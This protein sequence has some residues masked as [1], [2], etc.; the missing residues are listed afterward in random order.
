[1]TQPLTIKD[2]ADAL[3]EL[4]VGFHGNPDTAVTAATD[5]SRKVT[6]GALFCA[7]RGEKL[8]GH[9]FIAQ[10][11]ERGAAGV[12]LSTVPENMPSDLPYIVV[13][14]DYRAAGIAAE[15]AAGSP[16][17]HFKVLAVTG[18]N[19]KTTIAYLLREVL[20][21]AGFETAMIG[22][23]EYDLG[24]GKKITADRTTPTPFY[25]QNLFNEVYSNN[26][27]YCVMELSSHAIAQQRLGTLQVDGAIFTNLTQDHLDYHHTLENYFQAKKLLF[28]RHL[29]TGSPAV[30]NAD[31]PYGRR[32]AYEL[33]HNLAR[34]DVI[35]FSLK[36]L[37][38]PVC[39]HVKDLK[40]SA[41]G[42]EC[43]LTFPDGDWLMTS[44]LAG[45]YNGYNLAEVAILAHA[46][47]LPYPTVRQALAT[48]LGA[49][50]RLQKVTSSN[51][52]FNVFVD[53]AHTPDALQNVISTVRAITKGR[54]IVVFGCGGDRDR[55]K[56]PIMGGVVASIADMAIVTSDNPRTEAP[57]DI[58]KDILRGIPAGS[59]FAVEEDRRLAIR[60]ALS[61]A[62]AGD[63]VI[64]AGKGHEDYQEINGVKHHFSDVECVRSF[65]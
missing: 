15:T 41:T 42:T 40:L 23:V 46:L 52:N 56:R 35:S 12:I 1:M 63:S 20:K 10:A 22:T 43:A 11:V 34:A 33:T 48:C 51:H 38:T 62:S 65:L 5:D 18:T 7:I 13:S 44:P 59:R 60:L 61:E 4:R 30:I 64:I 9:D 32:L 2:Y 58:L 54:V 27:H 6:P 19:G 29:K 39:V 21:A 47:G 45:L 14:D 50:G 26:V 25:L 28:T 24:K 8:D 53:Y 36:N 3:G 55:T 37:C 31:D 57:D 17:Q 49:P 16:A